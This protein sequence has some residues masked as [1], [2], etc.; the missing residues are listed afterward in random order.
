ML[1]G[2]FHGVGLMAACSLVSSQAAGQGTVH[3]K[4]R[5][6]DMGTTEVPMRYDGASSLLGDSR[7]MVIHTDAEGN[8][9][10]TVDME[11][12]T[13]YNICRN[14]LYLTPGD[15]MTLTITQNNDEAEFEG[16]GAEVNNYMKYRLFPHG[17]SFLDGG[18]NLRADFASTQAMIDS[19]AAERLQ[20]LEQLTT[21]T[22]AFKR[23]EKA[24]VQADIL[25]SYMHF[26]SYFSYRPGQEGT[27]M[28]AL[29]KEVRQQ[30]AERA[31]AILTELNAP[32]LL[33]VNVVR[34]VLGVS[35]DGHY[36][37][38]TQGIV[39]ASRIRELYKAA[40]YANQL[41]YGVSVAQYDSL[42]R[43]IAELPSADFRK[44]LE[45]KLK[46]VSQLMPG[47]PAPDFKMTDME[48][49]EYRL[50]DLK[51]KLLYV[52]LWATWCGPCCQES[53][54]F[55]AMAEKFVGEDILF[56]PV[57]MDAHRKAWTD[58]V[59]YHKK[60]LFQYNSVD[61][62]LTRGWM[63]HGIPRFLIIDRDF[64]IVDAYAPRPSQEETEQLLRSLLK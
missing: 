2:F 37:D 49:K 55:E 25:N 29:D 58:Y 18:S 45:H 41:Q 10:M 34:S 21:A 12:P 33:D 48:G 17:G 53:P 11:A 31:R 6:L 28:R 46:T 35:E 1:K 14:T 50:S 62:E 27:D 3:L 38:W 63:I 51:G 20:Q 54:Y 47:R 8:F 23:L 32:D 61:G 30:C 52:D 24:R 7:D 39:F 15:D 44:E 60:K 43:E 19:L 59:T 56:V 36:S 26:A 64:N 9:D 57:S 4:G 42:T 5:L 16:Q 40:G 13:Y 22:P